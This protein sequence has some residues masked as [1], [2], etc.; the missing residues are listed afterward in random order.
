M[1]PHPQQSEQQPPSRRK[2]VGGAAAAVGAAT[3]TG[4][5]IGASTPAQARTATGRVTT[6]ASGASCTA[7]PNKYDE[8]FEVCDDELFVFMAN[9]KPFEYPG[10]FDTVVGDAMRAAFPGLKIK[11]VAWDQPVRYED[12]DKA[13]VVPDII[14]EDPRRRI[15]RDLEPR[16]W[17]RDLTDDLRATGIDLGS[18]NPGAV[19]QIKARSDGGLYGVPVFLDEY[20]MFHNKKVF[21]KKGLRTPANGVTYD[22]AFRLA[23]KLTFEQD[24]VAYKGYLQHPDMY[25]EFNQLGLYPFVPGRGGTPAPE[26][27]KVNITSEGWQ[28]LGSNLERFLLHPHNIFTTVDDYLTTGSVAMAVDNLRKLPAYAGSSLYL[29]EDDA[30]EWRELAKKID[31]GITSVPVLGS[32]DNAVYQPNTIAAFLPP[33]SSKKAQALQV[34]KWLVSQEGQTELSRHA[35]KPALRSGAVEAAFGTAIPELDRIDTSAVF[36]G[37]NAVVRDYENTEFWDLPLY[38]VFRQHVLRDGLKVSSALEITEKTDIPAY[39]KSQV[40]AGFDW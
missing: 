32:G 9:Y 29:E 14:L 35:L 4:V 20:I 30:D 21:D 18:L 17:T 28:R 24:L 23:K 22:E 1:T 6:S 10:F 27:V 39:I 12:L 26:D 8:P 19:A 36:W 25:L 15:D 16:A 11:A 5:G 33:Q 34:L 31:L 7:I 13:G 37:D 3:L 40:A 2:F 38:M